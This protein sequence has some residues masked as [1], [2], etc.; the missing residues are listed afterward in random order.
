MADRLWLVG[1]LGPFF[2][3]DSVPFLRFETAT[4]TVEIDASSLAGQASNAVAITGGTI[5]GVSIGSTSP[6]TILKSE[7]IILTTGNGTTE[8]DLD[9]ARALNT[10]MIS[11]A[12]ADVVGIIS[13]NLGYIRIHANI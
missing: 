9:S 8:V 10:A 13:T 11:S 12:T 4:G 7:Q 3:D 6:L 1:Q 5:D 2:F